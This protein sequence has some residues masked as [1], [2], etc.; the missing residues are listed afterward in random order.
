MKYAR[1]PGLGKDIS[2]IVQGCTMLREGELQGWSNSL[3]DEVYDAGINAFD[4]AWEY[5]DGQCERAFGNWLKQ[6]RVQDKVVIIGKGCHPFRGVNRVTPRYIESEINDSL[7]RL[8]VESI[9]LWLFHRDDPGVPVGPL[10]DT[11][12][13]MVEAGKI[14][15]F[16]GSNW[17]RAR[18]E[19]ANAYADSRGLQGFAASSPHFSLA[20]QMESPWGD[21][22]ITISGPNNAGV[23]QWYSQAGLGVFCWSSLAGGFLSGRYTRKNR[24]EMAADLPPYTI[25]SYVCED[26]WKRLE[27]AEQLAAEKGVTI[28]QIA[29]AYVLNQPMNTFAL[30]RSSSGATIRMNCAAEGLRLSEMELGWL[31][32]RHDSR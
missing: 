13:R 6:R 5:G 7:A 20:Q 8:G 10:I 25:R 3:L 27:R 2:R 17:T 22:C 11:L 26:N 15:T 16:G 19:E 32:L 9:D 18:I 31:D 28:A 12:N 23:R 14:R 24:D 1:I 29:L 30:V 4:H 21:D